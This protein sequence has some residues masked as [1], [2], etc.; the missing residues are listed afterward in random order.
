MNR[1]SLPRH[2]HRFVLSC[3]A[4]L[5]LVFGTLPSFAQSFE[6]VA[7]EKHGFS[8]EQFERLDAHMQGYVEDGKLAGLLTLVA[9]KGD[10]I[11][12]SNAGM[13]DIATQKPMPRDGIFR[14]ASMTKP[15][16]T[17]ALLILQEEGT[18]HIDDPVAKYL[19][20]YADMKVWVSETERA[21]LA[22]AITIKDVIMHTSGMASGMFPQMDPVDQLYVESDIFRNASSVQE[23]VES[24]PA[25]PLAHQPGERWTYSFGQDVAAH[26]VEL[27][28]GQPF[29]MFLQ[30]RILNPLEMHDTGFN[31][32]AHQ[33]SRR[34]TR[35]APPAEPDQP[36]R[37]LPYRPISYP[38]GAT[39]LHSTATDYVRFA[40]MLLNKGE[41]NGVRILQPESVEL[42]TTNHLAEDLMP[43]GV[44]PFVIPGYGFGLGVAVMLDPA[45]GADLKTPTLF[46]NS[47]H[48]PP[49]G[50][51]FWPG[52]LNT[53][54]FVDPTH[55]LI[56]LVMTQYTGV[57]DYDLLGDLQQFIYPILPN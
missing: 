30:E 19:P 42:M 2:M 36:L 3:G 1:T 17:V 32:Q 9:H 39:G 41:L 11:H 31:L 20:A 37:A 8:S 49:K 44:G 43:F 48:A 5:F 29:D 46:A 24:V 47:D 26:I 28:S 34:I 13:Q 35:Y 40:Q 45:A 56:G 4:I 18:L 10:I 12:F 14:I 25:L 53:Y 7:P 21:P 33:E 16:A 51:F 52:A 50:T 23:L 57:G 38:R 27:V 22:R 15:F 55:D 6:Q 54:F